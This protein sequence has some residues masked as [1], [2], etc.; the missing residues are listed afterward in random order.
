MT[1]PQNSGRVL[2]TVLALGFSIAGVSRSLSA[3]SM[4]LN[5]L[6]TNDDGYDAAGIV[7]VR[8]ALINAGHRV[9]LVAPSEN[10]SG[11]SV[12]LTTSGV[13]AYRE[14][15]DG[16]WSV[17]GSPADAVLIGLLNIMRDDLPDLVVS[18]ANFGQNLGYASSS[19]TV[20]AATFAI[21]AGIPAIAISVGIDLDERTMQ[22]TPFVSTARTF[23][24]AADFVVGLIRELQASQ[25]DADGLLPSHT[26]LNVNHPS[27]EPA[28]I[29]GTRLVAAGRGGGFQVRYADTDNPEELRVVLESASAGSDSSG[30]T[31]TQLFALGY[32]T[33]SVL[34][35]IWDA[36]TLARTSVS[37]RLS[38]IN[39]E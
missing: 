23:P 17:A 2:W 32:I 33:I 34:D 35:G 6:L 38:A 22:P 4:P 15:E 26:L 37:G 10:Q 30:D 8:S 36:G 18:G 5:I 3:Q 7:A 12:R 9:T 14:H 11:S 13:I 24:R 1:V 29:K 21:Y 39:R 20:G 28:D 27:L 16:V 31:D 25:S 19:G